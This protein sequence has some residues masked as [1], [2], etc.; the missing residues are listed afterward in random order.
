MTD[1]TPVTPAPPSETPDQTT[2]HAGPGETQD[3]AARGS[4]R[5]QRPD[6][7][8]FKAFITSGWALRGAR[9]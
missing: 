5:S 9:R 7:D 2:E 4:N 3:L 1:A 6:S 8:A